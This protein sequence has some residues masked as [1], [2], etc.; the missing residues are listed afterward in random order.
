MGSS[1]IKYHG[2]GFWT[3]DSFI[4]RLAGDVAEILNENGAKEKWIEDVIAHWSQQST[5]VF[6]GWVHLKLDEFLDTQEKLQK[7]REGVVRATT[8]YPEG[9]PFHQT[10]ILLTQLLDGQIKTTAESPLDYKVRGTKPDKS[11]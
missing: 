10:G 6:N 8:R 3:R 4:E 5:G 1:F 2:C 7:L 9:D 11:I